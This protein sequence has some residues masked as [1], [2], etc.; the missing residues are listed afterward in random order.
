MHEPALHSGARPLRVAIWHWGRRGGG[1]QYSYEVARQLARRADVRLSLFL[2][3]GVEGRR[4]YDALPAAAWYARTY[5]STHPSTQRRSTDFLRTAALVLRFPAILVRFARR[6]RSQDVVL[7]TMLH[8][9]N[10]LASWL[11]RRSGAR[12]VVVLHEPTSDRATYAAI[13]HRM[14]DLEVGRADGVVLLSDAAG[15]AFQAR[16]GENRV[17]RMVLP[18]G[19][20]GVFR[21]GRSEPRSYPRNRPVRL[22]FFGRIDEYKGIGLL[23]AAYDRLWREGRPVSLSIVGAG[24]LDPYREALAGAHDVEVCNRWVDE[25]EI[26]D[27]LASH[28]ICVL[29]YLHSSQSAV[30]PMA[31]YA[32][33]PVVTTPVGGLVEQVR[34]GD[35]GVIAEATTPEAVAAAIASLLSP[36]A[37]EDISRQATDDARQRLD[38]GAIGDQLMGF[39]RTVARSE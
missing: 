35:T 1:A 3:A 30:A 25:A 4:D 29:P 27:I 16:F 34:S 32:G 18:L 26:G 19:P 5:S 28:D 2:S 8:P 23:V 24:D 7:C 36:Q 39:L 6:L 21:H 31:Q 38:W 13:V 11:I 33:L 20:L 12:Y 17:P 37:Y 22:L 15:R 9:L 14:T 10:S